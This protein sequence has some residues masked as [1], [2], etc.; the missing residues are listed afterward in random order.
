MAD[1]TM[2]TVVLPYGSQD[3]FVSRL[4][5]S[6][7][8]VRPLELRGTYHHPKHAG[9]ARILGEMCSAVSSLRLPGAQALRWPLRSTAD[10]QV[11][12][13]GELHDTAI[14]TILCQR[15][16][17][18]PTVRAAAAGSPELR[19]AQFV[20][21]GS[22][23]CVPPS[24][25][26]AATEPAT[27]VPGEV[28]II[29]MASRFSGAADPDELWELIRSGVARASKVPAGRFGSATDEGG[30]GAKAGRR[31]APAKFQGNFLDAPGAFDHRFFGISGLEAKS[32]DPQQRLILQVAYEALESA[33]GHYQ[34]GAAAGP[35][36]VGCYLGVGS[37]DYE[38]NVAAHDA[39]AFAATGTLR[40]F[41]SGR[42]SHF[43]GWSGPSL[44]IDTACSSSAVAIHTACR[45]GF[46]RSSGIARALCSI[47]SLSLPRFSSAGVLL[48]RGLLFSA[49]PQVA[50]MALSSALFLACCCVALSLLIR[51]S[52]HV[53]P[54]PL[55]PPSLHCH[56]WHAIL[57]D[58]APAGILL[59]S[60]RRRRCS[61]ANAPWPWPGA[62]MSSLRLTS[63]K[64]SQPPPSSG[65]TARRG[66]SM[67]AP[68]DTAEERAPPWSS[69]SHSRAPWPIGITYWASL[70]PRP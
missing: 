66:H 67:P 4:R 42:V 11:I 55:R 28:A 35:A 31:P 60:L 64:T 48:P 1:E 30:A 27:K 69:S 20:S 45:V 19:H 33:G 70:P 56:P 39:N 24:L 8:L 12:T 44:T 63:T 59:T 38:R 6:K 32:M 23:P 58:L 57:H 18:F 50:R 2:L 52:L 62:S 53:F 40:A 34:T 29:G 46:A 49:L 51:P 16:H 41:I 65:R 7:T 43:F 25:L 13:S 10:G 54:R 15:A 47:L 22:E 21:L 3:S 37:A 5:G 17:W 9:S 26:R 61:A 36:N 68:A 14:Q